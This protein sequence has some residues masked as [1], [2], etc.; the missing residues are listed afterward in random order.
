MDPEEVD[1]EGVTF[2]EMEQFI[3]K[4]AISPPPSDFT[5]ETVQQTLD[6]NWLLW[7]SEKFRDYMREQTGKD[8]GS[9]SKETLKFLSDYLHKRILEHYLESSQ[10]NNS[11]MF[12]LNFYIAVFMGV[13]AIHHLLIWAGFTPP[14]SILGPWL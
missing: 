8:F 2:E 12:R 4:S 3:E 6:M 1:Q 11:L 7:R 10:E 13:Q 14:D 5:P 9:Q